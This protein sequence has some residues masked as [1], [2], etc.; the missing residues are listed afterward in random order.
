MTFGMCAMLFLT[1]LF[2]QSAHGGSAL[3]AGI[4]LLPLSAAKPA[5]SRPGWR[6]PISAAASV[7]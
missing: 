7:K 1:P 3:L 6:P 4:E 5:I 2:L